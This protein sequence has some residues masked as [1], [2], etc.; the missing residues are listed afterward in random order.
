MEKAG[1][2]RII[3][4]RDPKQRDP[5]PSYATTPLNKGLPTQVLEECGF[6]VSAYNLTWRLLTINLNDGAAHLKEQRR[7]PQR[8]SGRIV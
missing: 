5:Q 1:S 3:I 7:G 6:Q 4:A 8:T 2:D